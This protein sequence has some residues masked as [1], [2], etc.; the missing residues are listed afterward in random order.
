[1]I[2]AV[3]RS[4]G[5]VRHGVGPPAAPQCPRCP[6]P[7]V[8]GADQVKTLTPPG[9]TSNPTMMTMMPGNT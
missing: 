3:A 4:Q 6:R 8:K 5:P 9:P 2:M 7:S 1:M